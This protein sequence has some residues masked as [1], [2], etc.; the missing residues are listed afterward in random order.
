MTL[1]QY[2]GRSH[3]ERTSITPLFV[4]LFDY[5][6]FPK[7]EFSKQPTGL[8]RLKLSI[9]IV[10]IVLVTATDVPKYSKYDLQR[11]LETVLKA[12]IPAP[13]L[14]STI[15]PVTSIELRKKLKAHFP[16]VY[17]EKSHIDCYNFCQ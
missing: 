8:S 7:S 2:R 13:A 5:S 4:V 1:V 14:A 15:A 17:R 10:F 12:Q 11:I 6:P 9:S 16:D 3:W